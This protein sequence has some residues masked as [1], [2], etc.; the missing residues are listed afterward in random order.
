MESYFDHVPVDRLPLFLHD[1]MDLMCGREGR[2]RSEWIPAVFA[3]DAALERGRA[4][5][6]QVLL[7]WIDTRDQKDVSWSRSLCS[8]S[9][10]CP[11][12]FSLSFPSPFTFPL[13]LLAT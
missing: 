6:Q 11:F 5:C 12:P 3:D 4:A 9:C 8:P 2:K 7:H 1:C 13:H 10:P